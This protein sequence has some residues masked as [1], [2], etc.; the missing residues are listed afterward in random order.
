MI[1]SAIGRAP[2]AKL[3][4]RQCGAQRRGLAATVS[5]STSF[6]YETADVAGVKTASRDIAG[7]TTK[8]AVV[9]KAGT[10][11][12]SGPGLTAGLEQFAFKVRK[13][14]RQ[15]LVALQICI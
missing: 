4:L 3:A 5:G 6:S 13:D 9:A 2:C 10:R 12:E 1:R 7:P 11:Y 8:L 15:S 14:L